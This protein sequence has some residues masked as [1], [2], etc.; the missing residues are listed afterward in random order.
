[1]NLS[2]KRICKKILGKFDLFIPENKKINFIY[3]LYRFEEI[4]E[5]EL[6]N[7]DFFIKKKGNAIDIGSNYGLWCYKL[8]KIKN[9][10]KIYAFEPNLKLSKVKSN[11]FKKIKVYGVA[12]S[13][14]N[15]E[16]ILETP[17]VNNYEYHGLSKI[18]NSKEKW[19]KKFINFKKRQIKIKKLDSYNFTNI[20]FIKIDAEGHELKVLNGG[21]KFF[22][23]NKPNC[24]IE[25]KNKNFTKVHN[26]FLN[27]KCKYKV[28][29]KSYK[30]I[31][32][33]KG[34]YLYSTE[35]N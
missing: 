15:G 19:P 29:K 32:L 9:I 16:K 30:G 21:K 2:I 14:K 31:K 24:I 6:F 25:I 7:L 35:A 20:S 27:L 28:S 13:N 33:T 1:M 11:Y 8:S 17:I 4:T 34:N 26:F 5:R 23:K 10:D 12:L 18:Y 3:F 22:L